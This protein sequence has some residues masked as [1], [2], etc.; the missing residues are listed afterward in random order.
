M[1]VVPLLFNQSVE[2][3]PRAIVRGSAVKLEMTGRQP[4]FGLVTPPELFGGNGGG[5]GTFFLH[6]AAT[7]RS[8]SAMIMAI[9]FKKC[10]LVFSVISRSFS[11]ALRIVIAGSKPVFRCFPPR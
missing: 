5:G 11:C 8:A 9:R 1:S 10:D 4:S 3:C 7:T 2:L 6:P